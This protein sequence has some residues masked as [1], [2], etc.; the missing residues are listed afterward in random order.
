MI[1]HAPLYQ[2]IN[3]S[4]D[5]DHFTSQS[6]T[7]TMSTTLPAN[8]QQFYD[9]AAKECQRFKIDTGQ[10]WLRVKFKVC[11]FSSNECTTASII[12]KI[13]FFAHQSTHTHTLTRMNLT[14]LCAIRLILFLFC[15]HLLPA[16]RKCTSS[17]GTV[18]S[19]S[20]A[21]HHN[22]RRYSLAIKRQPDRCHEIN[23]HSGDVEMPAIFTSGVV[24][25]KDVVVVMETLADGAEGNAQILRG[26]DSFIIGPVPP[27]M[28][29]WINQPCGV[30]TQ[31]IAQDGRNEVSIPQSLA[32]EVPR[33]HRRDHETAQHH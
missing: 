6:T 10:F 22:S 4:Y 7:I 26:V 3:N 18:A 31:C 17:F 5:V 2:L 20:L 21:L 23:K 33:N 8:Q 13:R 32:P 25:R 19:A 15:P 11:D 12:P 14:S 29:S 24:V 27:H 1:P 28:G 16:K 30:E 9:V